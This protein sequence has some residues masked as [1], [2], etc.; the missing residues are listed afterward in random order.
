MNEQ[1]YQTETA[2][3]FRKDSFGFALSRLKFENQTSFLDI[4]FYN[5]EI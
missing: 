4:L 1:D 3:K 5:L 2:D